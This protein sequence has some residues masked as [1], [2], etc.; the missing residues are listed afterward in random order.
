MVSYNQT[1]NKGDI[2][3]TRYNLWLYDD[4]H[5]EKRLEVYNDYERA[6]RRGQWCVESTNI[7]FHYDRYE[8]IAAVIKL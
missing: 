1:E 2:K 6:E 4:K 7:H 8:I 3:M 5:N